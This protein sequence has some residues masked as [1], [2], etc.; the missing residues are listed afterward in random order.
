MF[1]CAGVRCSTHTL[2][3]DAGV[4]LGEVVG[5]VPVSFTTSSPFITSGEGKEREQVKGKDRKQKRRG[6]Y[7]G[8]LYIRVRIFSIFGIKRKWQF[9]IGIFSSYIKT[10]YCVFVSDTLVD[11]VN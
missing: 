11:L 10:E 3:P 5:G 8:V 2:S 7:R 6:R 9:F 1:T 4:L